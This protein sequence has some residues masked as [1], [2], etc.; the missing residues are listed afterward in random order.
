MTSFKERR[1]ALL[2]DAGLHGSEFARAYAA[3]ADEWLG[4]LLGDEPGVTLV[5]LGGYGRAEMCPHSDLDVLLI[6]DGHRDV[7]ALAERVWYPIWDAGVRLD[8][9]V[10]TER[11]TLR[12][13]R[14]DLK[15]AMGLLDA[16][17]VAGAAT[18]ATELRSKAT[19]QW[20]EHGR[21]FL[22]ELSQS[23]RQRH[24]AHSDV[25]FLLEPNLKE[26][27]GGLRDI[28]AL[29]AAAMAASFVAPVDLGDDA[30]ELLQSA[31]IELHRGSDRINDRLLLQDQDD[32]AARL[33]Y[34]DADEFMAAVAGAA[35]RVAWLSDDAWRKVDGW[36][37]GP[38]ASRA[39]R[40]RAVGPGLVI[41]DGEL[42]LT[43]PLAETDDRLAL[44]AAAAAAT[45]GTPLSHQCLARLGELEPLQGPW[46]ADA[47]Q[48]LIDL[49]GSGD[50]LVVVFEALD[51]YGVWSRLMPE[52]EP[53][54]SR[55]Q[56][57]A[58]H[59]FT[60]DRHLIEATRNAAAGAHQVERPDL[61][62]VG[63]LLHDIGKGYPGDHSVVGAELTGTIATRMGFP[64]ADVEVLQRMVRLHLLLPDIAGRRDLDDPGTI[65]SV[66][67]QVVDVCTLELLEALSEAD[68]GATGDAASSPWR[69][70]LL[71]ELVGRV[72][73]RL[74]GRPHRP[75]DSADDERLLDQAHG[76]LL[77]VGEDRS[78][79]VVAPDRPGLL[80]ATAGVLNLNG[81]DVVTASLGA[82]RDGMVV[83]TFR[84]EP[85]FA[86]PP[87]WPGVERDLN[88]V[89]TGELP[90]AERLREKERTYARRSPTAARPPDTGV[91]FDNDL[92]ASATVVEVRA[93]D[94]IGL[95]YRIAS[96]LGELGLD[97]RHATVSTVGHQAVDSF[98]VV[99]ATGSKLDAEQR[100]EVET[101]ISAEVGEP[102]RTD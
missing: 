51:H 68:A 86:R 60:V 27:K 62:V 32:V 72:R 87:D 76:K 44:R 63:A 57:N 59:R 90:L 45:R 33:G 75:P 97:I 98:Y 42:R 52:W 21:R 58:Y 99:G 77:L 22:A 23:T 40:D 81:L 35:R 3:L 80:S 85:M 5:A 10:R 61:L 89:L 71:G 30:A 56:R 88:R 65:D 67:S 25:A 8:H 93:P 36:L 7:A 46:P 16:R 34:S 43:E 92:S 15:V 49:L 19:S 39:A 55:P 84:V 78:V 1:A 26:A 79:K 82:A 54:R 2:A 17:L 47:R 24:A 94:A 4:E 74:E 29:R 100:R 11:E 64:A 28:T 48:A 14:S 13:G 102:A 91:M 69:R 18:P 96:V 6:H 70:T 53:V 31:R 73:L 101:A 38:S 37:A 66:A 9:S 41:R 12:L 83:D 50:A 20:Y 95:L